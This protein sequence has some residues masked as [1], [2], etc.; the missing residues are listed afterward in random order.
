MFEEPTPE[1]RGRATRVVRRHARDER[2]EAEL[3]AM[4]GL[5]RAEPPPPGPKP[6]GALTPAEVHDLVAPFAAEHA[7][8][9]DNA[10]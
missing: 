7:R 4:L 9:A 3:M 6:R 8:R 1:E 10:R 2:D 5:D